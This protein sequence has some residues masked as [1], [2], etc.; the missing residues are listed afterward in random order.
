MFST[1][2][3]WKLNWA[4]V[5]QVTEQR[6]RVLHS[7]YKEG[8]RNQRQLARSC[9]NRP[10]RLRGYLFN[11]CFP[12]CYFW[13]PHIPTPLQ[14]SGITILFLTG[15]SSLDLSPIPPKYRPTFVWRLNNRLQKK[16]QQL[17]RPPM[18]NNQGLD[19]EKIKPRNSVGKRPT[20]VSIPAFN[21]DAE[22]LVRSFQPS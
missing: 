2:W 7:P 1:I 13:N 19:L 21:P 3:R 16:Q 8:W 15:L 9:Q 17:S 14:R 20:S 10:S 4:V 5:G 12:F 18:S 6:E 11:I 22:A